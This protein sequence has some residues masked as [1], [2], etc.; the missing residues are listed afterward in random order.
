MLFMKSQGDI[1]FDIGIVL[2]T[3]LVPLGF[4]NSFILLKLKEKRVLKRVLLSLPFVNIF[5]FPR[6]LGWSMYP[7]VCKVMMTLMVVFSVLVIIFFYL[8]AK[9]NL[10]WPL[11][12][13]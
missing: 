7:K 9:E 12:S 11:S 5:T 8:G 4:V 10:S 3:A 13:P 1:L 2:M 6:R